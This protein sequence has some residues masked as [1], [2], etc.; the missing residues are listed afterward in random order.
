MTSQPNRRRRWPKVI[1]VVA[2]LICM[3]VFLLFGR[4][5]AYQELADWLSQRGAAA[6]GMIVLLY[7]VKSLTVLWPLLT[8]YLLSGILFPTPMAVLVNLLGL[9]A[10]DTAP[11]L[12]GRL[13]GSAELDRLREKYP[14]L[15]LLETLRRKGGFQFAVLSRAVGLLPGDVVSLY[16]GCTGLSYP[17]YLAGSVLGLA[18]G[19]IAATTLGGQIS[20]PGSVGFWVSAI[21]GLAVAAIS[22][23][24]C[25]RVIKRE[26][27]N[28]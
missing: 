10:C 3:S 13:L 14:K 27:G 6:V 21:S 25:H 17:A 4:S 24:A 23:L 8:L 7:T 28:L 16:F 9:A 12:L 18:P 19:M 15:A 26:R 11:Y 22:F 2:M 20:D 5:L 1:S